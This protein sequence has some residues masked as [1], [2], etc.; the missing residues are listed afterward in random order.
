M[1]GKQADLSTPWSEWQ[2]SEQRSLWYITRHDPS[3][4]LETYWEEV[5]EDSIPQEAEYAEP[6]RGAELE[7]SYTTSIQSERYNDASTS[8]YTF[9]LP[10]LEDLEPDL[11]SSFSGID[12]S[13]PSSRGKG[14]YNIRQDPED[15][16]F[17]VIS[18][19]RKFFKL[20]RVFKTLWSE[21]AG[22][23]SADEVANIEP[24]RFGGTVFTKMRTFVVVREM[25]GCSICLPLFTYNGQGTLKSGV[26]PENHAA[27]YPSDSNAPS[28]PAENLTKSPYPI[29]VEN[30]SESIDRMSRLNFGKVY[31]VEHNLKV[32]KVGRIPD[33][34]HERLQ[35]DYVLAIAGSVW[36]RR[37][38]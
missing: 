22:E 15:S 33:E 2:W 25:K 30:P 27:V 37:Y 9:N 14:K 21:P 10:D 4:Q 5:Q 26:R 24:S 20:G 12:I 11:Q 7:A 17:E 29:I 13:G 3:G 19:P 36:K 28:F 38:R 23:T 32:L 18:K 16:P 34:C 1:S 35:D 6:L 8:D 31:T